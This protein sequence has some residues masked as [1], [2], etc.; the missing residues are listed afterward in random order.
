MSRAACVLVAVLA[1]AGSARADGG[2]VIR[3]T[4]TWKGAAPPRPPEDRSRD[5]VCAEHAQASEEIVVERGG[6]RDVLVR[7]R[8]GTAGTHAAPAAPAV[9][10]QDGCTYAPRV[11]GVLAGQAVE[12]HNGDPTFH[13]VRGNRD[14]RVVWNLAQ[15]ATSPPLVRRELGKPGDIVDLHCDVHP[16]MQA[17]IAVHDHPYFT[18]TGSGGAF[19]LRG[20]PPGAYV[21]EAWHP[22]LG[23]RSTKVKVRKGK[24]TR[25][26]FTLAAPPPPT[27]SREP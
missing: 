7:L 14:G 25:A 2:G 12:I 11:L 8:N 6:V 19:E 4:V 23:L 5:P 18:V 1:V 9:L 20:V 15:P 10:R 24:T 17:W 13:N 3:G 27:P 16:W 22:L 21:L 26:T